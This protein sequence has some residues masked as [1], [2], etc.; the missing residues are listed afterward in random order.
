[1]NHRIGRLVFAFGVGILL[2]FAS[3]KWITNPEPRLERQQQESAVM[4]ARE[5]LEATIGVAGLE[6]VDPLA[7]NRKVGKSY[8]YRAG[9]GWEVSGYYRRGEDDLW[10]PYLM[11]L[12]SSRVMTHLKV[13]DDSLQEIAAG[14]DLVE[15]IR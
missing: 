5:Q 7:Q 9:E 15:V 1:M 3:Y 11:S 8:V 13:Q 12:N 4:A 14:N 6:V 10:H 2:A